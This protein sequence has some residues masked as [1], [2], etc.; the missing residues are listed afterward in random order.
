F[1]HIRYPPK[2]LPEGHLQNEAYSR[3]RRD[4]YPDAGGQFPGPQNFDDGYDAAAAHTEIENMKEPTKLIRR[5]YNTEFALSKEYVS[6]LEEEQAGYYRRA[7]KGVTPRDHADLKP[8]ARDYA[9]T[10][11]R[12][13]NAREQLYA[14]SP[15]MYGT[16]DSKREHH[17][18]IS[19]HY[20]YADKAEGQYAQHSKFAM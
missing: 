20:G 14:Q 4:K 10:E 17:E 1:C 6:R 5:S 15:L 7:T 2:D 12:H 19:D 3:A 13:A 11:Y 18:Y 16:A 9:D 8:L